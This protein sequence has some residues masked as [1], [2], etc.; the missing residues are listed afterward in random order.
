[1]KPT[2]AILALTLTTGFA[3][4]DDDGRELRLEDCPAPVRSTIES[5]ARGGHVEEVEHIAIGDREIY[6][7][8]I[9]LPGDLDLTVH[10]LGNG[11]LVKTREDVAKE[12]IPAFASSLASDRGGHLDDV[13]KEVASGKTT[14]HIE[15]DRRGQP[16]LD[17]ITDEAGKIL[18][19]TEEHDD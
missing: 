10:V 17:L 2:P 14:Y 11:S 19:E 12:A 13:D 5:N 15:I 6:L 4:A 8:E 9:D 18:R 3:L 7:A 1:M 16:D